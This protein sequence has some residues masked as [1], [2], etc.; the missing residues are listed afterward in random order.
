[1][2]SRPRMKH[3]TGSR[4]NSHEAG[5]SE[6]HEQFSWNGYGNSKVMYYVFSSGLEFS[7][8][9]GEVSM[10]NRLREVRKRIYH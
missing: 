10:A 8:E 9:I 2:S 5:V 7:D 4:E 6:L 1:V 3:L